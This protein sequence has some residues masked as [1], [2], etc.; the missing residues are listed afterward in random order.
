MNH[1]NKKEIINELHKKIKEIRRDLNLEDV[2][3]EIVDVEVK[4]ENGKTSLIIYTLTR[5]D[6]STI[7]GPGGWVVGKLREELKDRFDSITVEDYTDVLVYKKR[8]EERL[9]FFENN[10][11]EF[12]KDVVHYL[13]KNEI[14]LKKE[15][16][17]V[18]VQC[19][20]DLAIL[21]ILNKVYDVHAITYDGGGVVLPPKTKQKIEEFIK[22]KNIKHE[23]IKE[24]LSR[25]KTLN[26][27]DNYPCGF[28][29]DIIKEKAKLC[30]IKYVFLTCLDGDYKIE[31]DIYFINFLKMF[32]IRLKKDNYLDFCPLLI[33]SY[34]SKNSNKIKIIDEIVSDVYNGLKEPTEATEEI[35]KV[36]R[37]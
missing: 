6:K 35:L 16:V 33:Q 18:L 11:L 36:V 25:E 24:K 20:H 14:P 23:Y 7:I 27:I 29:K 12:L 13:I 22:S 3:L 10:N 32:P 30:N 17:M 34:K 37:G 4:K 26:L 15:K 21:D 2:P 31:D 9:R 19:K 1:Q 8:L 28:I 5:S